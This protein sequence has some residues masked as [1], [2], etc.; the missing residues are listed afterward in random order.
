M[1]VTIFEPLYREGQTLTEPLFTPLQVSQTDT[2]A[3]R[4]FRIIVDF[5]RR[6]DH[7]RKGLVGVFSP[8]FGLKTKIPARAFIEF[9]QDNI[10]A[11]VCFINPFPQIEYY[12]YNVWMQGEANHP[13][14]TQCAQALLDACGIGWVVGEVPRHDRSTLCYSNFWVGTSSFW[15]RYVGGVL[16]PIAGFL[17]K[18]PDHH[19]ARAVMG[20]TWHTDNAPFLP[21][22]IERLFSTYLS[23]T[24]AVKAAAYPVGDVTQYCLNDFERDMVGSMIPIVGKAVSGATFPQCLFDTQALLCRLGVR[25]AR[26]YFAA[27]A[28]PHSGK[29]VSE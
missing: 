14:I 21:F 22:I 13:G 16:D 8:K 5:Y 19:A 20:D 23:M 12:S 28:H 9:S 18:N 27:N 26:A 6:G 3:W 10:G 2:S 24:P 15:E 11:D 1:T 4:E 25:Y 17:E 7:R 29:T